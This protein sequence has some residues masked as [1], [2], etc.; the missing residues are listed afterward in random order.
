MKEALLIIDMLNDFV[1]EGGTLVVPKARDIIPNIKKRLDEAHR[2]GTPVI[3]M[4]DAH[5]P[6]D[7]EFEAWGPHAI[8]GTWGHE[9]IEEL[10][11][12]EGEYVLHKRKYSAFYG[13]DLDPFLRDFRIEK[14]IITGTLTNICIYYTAIDAVMRDYKVV[15]PRDCVAAITDEEHNFALN[16]METVLKAEVI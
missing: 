3:Y 1:K 5:L 14:I 7:V 11:P 12:R 6:N 13:T 9:I 16:Q 10:K 15:V 4:T 8:P 2:A